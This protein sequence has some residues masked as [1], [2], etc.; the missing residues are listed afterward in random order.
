MRRDT[1]LQRLTDAQV[2]LV[3]EAESTGTWQGSHLST[4]CA[5]SGTDGAPAVPTFSRTSARNC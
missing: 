2:T 3:N 1:P 4:N 5:R